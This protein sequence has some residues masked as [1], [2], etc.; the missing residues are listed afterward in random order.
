[1][2]T[3]SEDE[4]IDVGHGVTIQARRLDGR[5]GGFAWWHSCKDGRRA[6]DY[7][8]T[9]P[10][11]PNP[12]WALE[13]ESPVTLSPSILCRVCGFHGHVVDGRWIPT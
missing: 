9:E 7:V 13:S 3:F 5:V 12:G 10:V 4:P 6:E 1:M 11:G 2:T 8:N